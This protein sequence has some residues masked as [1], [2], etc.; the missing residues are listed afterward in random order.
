MRRFRQLRYSGIGRSGEL[1]LSGLQIL[2]L[3]CLRQNNFPRPFW[4]GSIRSAR[5]EALQLASLGGL[6]LCQFFPP[7]EAT[8]LGGRR[9]EGLPPRFL[10]SLGWI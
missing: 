4:A 2:C 1:F 9:S 3:A 7:D 6:N 10:V 5:R 8:G